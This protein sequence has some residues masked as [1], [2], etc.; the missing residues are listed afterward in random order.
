MVHDAVKNDMVPI[1]VDVRAW[2]KDE[3]DETP[4]GNH[5]RCGALGEHGQG[6]LHDDA[7]QDVDCVLND[8]GHDEAE[9]HEMLS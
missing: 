4:G 1:A 6:G 8:Q 9:D 7:C 5:A 3:E 2:A